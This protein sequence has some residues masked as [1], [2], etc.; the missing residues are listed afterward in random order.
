MVLRRA[1]CS[2]RKL[3]AAAEAAAERKLCSAAEAATERKLYSAAE[4][5]AERKTRRPTDIIL[6]NRLSSWKERKTH[7]HFLESE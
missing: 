3:C 5:A 7:S 1:A 2:Q 4:A 6:I